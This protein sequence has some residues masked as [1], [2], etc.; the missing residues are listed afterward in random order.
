MKES[1]RLREISDALREHIEENIR[2][3]E[4]VNRALRVAVAAESLGVKP[5]RFRVNA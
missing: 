4:K 3:L 2:K 1:D 5:P